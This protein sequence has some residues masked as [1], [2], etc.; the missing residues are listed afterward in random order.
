MRIEPDRCHSAGIAE[1]TVAAAARRLD[2]M[3]LSR[4]APYFAP[5]GS[6]TTER[7]QC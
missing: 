6:P 2:P 5:I 7:G 1:I 4:N 3:I